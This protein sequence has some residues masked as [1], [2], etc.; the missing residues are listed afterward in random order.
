MQTFFFSIVGKLISFNLKANKS[1]F[2]SEST[3][4]ANYCE[5]QFHFLTWS[6]TAVKS[7]LIISSRTTNRK[8]RNRRRFSK[9][10]NRVCNR[11]HSSGGFLVYN[12]ARRRVS[13]LGKTRSSECYNSP[14]HRYSRQIPG[15]VISNN[16]ILDSPPDSLTKPIKSIKA[17]QS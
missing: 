8:T 11:N 2:K 14:V 4:T 1:R 5:C 7:F 12:R 13:F 15:R 10:P 6:K 3:S 17:A 9:Q 16:L